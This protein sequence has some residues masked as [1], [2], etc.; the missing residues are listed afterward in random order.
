MTNLA[1]SPNHVQS[2]KQLSITWNDTNAG[3]ATVSQSFY[4]YVEVKNLSTGQTLVSNWVYYD[5]AALGSLAAGAT[6]ASP[7]ISRHAARWRCEPSAT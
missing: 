1:V 5:V 7:A 3:A 2:G 4:D 6:S